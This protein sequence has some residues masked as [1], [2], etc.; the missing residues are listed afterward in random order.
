MQLESQEREWSY[1][2]RWHPLSGIPADATVAC[3]SIPAPATPVA[4]DNCDTEVELAYS[5]TEQAGSCTD[6]YVL[7]RTW[8]A[9]DNCGN[10]TV[11][12][13]TLTVEDTEAPILSG[14]PADAT[15]ACGSIP[16]PATPVA[17]DNCDTEV[18]LAYSETE[19]AG[20]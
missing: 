13:Q 2:Q 10:S 16:A 1:K 4:T 17:T 6:S 12:T 20:S 19:Q 14:I 5:E 11:E 9:M 18:E 8:T 3:S 7:L 15:V